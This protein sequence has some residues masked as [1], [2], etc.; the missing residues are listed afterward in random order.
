MLWFERGAGGLPWGLLSFSH[1]LALSLLSLSLCLCLC[2]SLSLSL[3]LLLSLCG[4]KRNRGRELLVRGR[5]LLDA[6]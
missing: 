6:R 2:L 5:E 1:S 4:K 3:F